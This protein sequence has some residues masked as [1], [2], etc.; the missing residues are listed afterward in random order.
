MP[1]QKTTFQRRQCVLESASNMSWWVPLSFCLGIMEVLRHFKHGHLPAML[2]PPMFFFKN[3]VFLCKEKEEQGRPSL[4][5]FRS[6]MFWSH[7]HLILP[8]SF[9]PLVALPSFLSFWNLKLK[10]PSFWLASSSRQPEPTRDGL[11]P[12]RV[13]PP[14]NSQSDFR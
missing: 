4:S 11:I 8:G 3:F 6:T 1:M 13:F 7:R 12:P 9:L 10:K 2:F 14:T 5:V